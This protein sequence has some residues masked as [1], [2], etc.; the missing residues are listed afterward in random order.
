MGL[1]INK[2]CSITPHKVCVDGLKIFDINDQQSLEKS[3]V[4]TY[5]NLE[6]EYPKFFK[7]DNLSKLAI[8]ASECLLKNTELYKIADKGNVAL[9]LSNASSSLVTDSNYHLTIDDPKNYFP[10]PSLFVYTLPNITIGEICI[11]H[12]IYGENIFFVSEHP[13][14]SALYVYVNELFERTNTEYCIAGWVECNVNTYEAF[15]LLVGKGSNGDTFDV[16]TIDNL[17]NTK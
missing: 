15:L 16:K 3:L 10:S 9:V 2:Y 13:D 1:I 5:R 6:L 8:L 11:K 4:Q 12:K 14:A 17:Y 7:M